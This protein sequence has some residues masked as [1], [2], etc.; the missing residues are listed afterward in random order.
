M[1][2]KSYFGFICLFFYSCIG[3]ANNHSLFKC[4]S[5]ENSKNCSLGCEK[6]GR[7]S[8][9]VRPL[10]DPNEINI[11]QYLKNETSPKTIKNCKI[12]NITNWKC[13]KEGSYST[14]EHVMVND[15]YRWQLT[16]KMLDGKNDVTQGCAKKD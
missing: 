8:F 15:K 5:L 6:I 2:F 12:F 7:I 10:S 1:N 3:L 14:S 16:Y 11:I 9:D 4:N 13:L